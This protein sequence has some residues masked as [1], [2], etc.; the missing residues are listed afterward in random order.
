MSTRKDARGIRNQQEQADN[1]VIEEELLDADGEFDDLQGYEDPGDAKLEDVLVMTGQT[2]E[3]DPDPFITDNDFVGSLDTDLSHVPPHLLT[4]YA[5]V[6][7][8]HLQFH[9]L[10]AACNVLLAVL[11]CLLLAI[12]PGIKTPFVTLQSL[13]RVLGVDAPILTLPVCPVCCNVYPPASSRLSHDECTDC[14]VPLFL[15]SQTKCGNDHSMKTPIVKY[16]YLPLSEQ[17]K[18]MLK[19]PGLEAIL[20]GWRLKPRSV[21]TYMDIFDGDM[22]HKKLKD[23]DGHLFFSNRPGDKTGPDSK[24]H[25][26]VNLGVDW[27]LS[28]SSSTVE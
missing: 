27:Q 11:A 25:I 23:P 1:K 13:N 2:G 22:C 19:I 17:I 10:R 16:P 6:T 24:L 15:P 12:S 8:L 26:G 14:N 20:D 4:T 21:G 18:S 28:R 5:L 3:D 9:L 7:W